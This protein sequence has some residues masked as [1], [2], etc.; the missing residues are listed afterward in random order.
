MNI[1][2]EPSYYFIIGTLLLSIPVLLFS[3]KSFFNKPG[4]NYLIILRVIL[5]FLIIVLF[6][7]P[8]LIFKKERIKS[9]L[10]HIYI[11]KSLSLNY[12][13]QPS[14]NALTKGLSNFIDYL[15]S[16]DIGFNIYSFGNELDTLLNIDNLKVDA[17]S[18]NIGLVFDNINSHYEANIAGG[19]IFTDGR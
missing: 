9:S 11:D 5:F 7:N 2:L 6:L 15:K 13:K 4:Y 10:W 8:T 12:Y 17:N 3:Y 19:I 16:K 14:N 18:T 1:I